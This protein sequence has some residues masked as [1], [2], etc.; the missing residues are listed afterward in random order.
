MTKKTAKAPKIAKARGRSVTEWIG[1]TPDSKP[2]QAVRLR[3][4]DRVHGKCHLTGTKI[5]PGDKWDLD[6][7]VRLE[8]GGE[9]RESN[10]APALKSPHIEKTAQETKRGRKADRQRARHIGAKPPS[11]NPVPQR[12]SEPKPEKNRKESP[13][14]H[15]GPC[16][17]A[18]RFR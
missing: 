9:N 16:G 17:I 1:K 10:L 4:F 8:D 7:I 6:H 15:L 5:Q 11:K 18:R 14:A 3:V 13:F 12:P 2:P